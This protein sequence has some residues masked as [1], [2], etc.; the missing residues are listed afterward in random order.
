MK[1]SNIMP[2]QYETEDDRWIAEA[3]KLILL[4][5]PE[6]QKTLKDFK[7]WYENKPSDKGGR[8]KIRTVVNNLMVL[9]LLGRFI[10]KDFKKAT[11]EDLKQFIYS[12]NGKADT[13]LANWKVIIRYFYKWLYGDKYLKKHIFPE[14]VDDPLFETKAK[15]RSKKIQ[16]SKDLLTKDQ[17][18]SMVQHCLN[19]MDKAKIMVVF[20]CGMRAGEIVSLNKSCVEFDK[21]GAKIWIPK[22]KTKERYVRCVDAVP[23]LKNWLNQH[24]FKDEN[25]P[26]FYG[27]RSYH[28]RRLNAAA[29]TQCLKATAKRA[30]IDPK[31]VWCHGLRHFSVTSQK[32]KL[33]LDVDT[34]AK[35]HGISPD[36]VRKV[37]LHYEDENADSDYLQA[38]GLKK[39][40]DALEKQ[41]EI[42]KTMPKK[43]SE[44]SHINAW[45]SNFC[46]N[47]L[48]DKKGNVRLCGAPLD[49]KAALEKDKEKEEEM[50]NMQTRLN[51]MEELILQMAEKEI[52][53]KKK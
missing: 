15:P 27:Q 4:T 49:V 45:D 47:E 34:I 3:D 30:G 41:E 46:Q 31:K 14:V 35:L 43:C 28:G 21:Y 36:T 22:S 29:M 6:Q 26:L 52:K 23:Y 5:N 7:Q 50:N 48:K 44:C 25:S 33:G 12:L 16:R 18:M 39:A 42:K 19:D 53:Q 51:K 13:T 24:A 8:I 10:K 9:S 2:S 32:T 40:E 37:Y 38:R 1:D 11:K 20:E 17:V